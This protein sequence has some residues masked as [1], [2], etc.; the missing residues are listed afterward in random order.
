MLIGRTVVLFA[1]HG[2]L[3]VPVNHH[4]SW[5]VTRDMAQT[6][7]DMFGLT[8][9]VMMMLQRI[10]GFLQYQGRCMGYTTTAN[11]S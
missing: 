6:D 9:T 2:L 3:A 7:R 5:S 4:N 8:E 11:C 1:V 10:D